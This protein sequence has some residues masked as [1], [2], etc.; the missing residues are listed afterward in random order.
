MCQHE[1]E[2]VKITPQSVGARLPDGTVVDL[3]AAHLQKHGRTSPH[4]RDAVAFRLS[5]AYGV[6]L[7]RELLMGPGTKAAA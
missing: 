6:D 5:A 2:I 4:L 1:W 3:Q 7:V